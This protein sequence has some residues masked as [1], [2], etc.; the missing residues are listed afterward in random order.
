MEYLLPLAILGVTQLLAAISP[1]HSFILIS[2][3]ALSSP[4]PVSLAA[5]MGLGVGTIVWASPD[6]AQN[7][8]MS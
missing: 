8:P 3:L 4:R 2:R 7:A 6:R 5:V 1:G